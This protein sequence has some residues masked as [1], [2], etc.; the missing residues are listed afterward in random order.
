MRAISLNC[1]PPTCRLHHAAELRET[2]RRKAS[3]NPQL[4]FV[5]RLRR[6]RRTSAGELVDKEELESEAEPVSTD[7]VAVEYVR[8]GKREFFVRNGKHR[9][10]PGA[11]YAEGDELAVKETTIDRTLRGKVVDRLKRLA[12]PEGYPH[13]VGPGFVEY[14]RWRLSAFFFGGAVG[15]FSTQG[16]LLAVGVGRQSA[17]PLAAALQWVIRDGMGRAGRMLFS[18]VGNGFDAETKQ[19]RLMAGFVLNLSCALESVTPAVPHLFLPLACIANM[20]KGAS[21]V[22]AASTRSA[23]YLSFMRRENLG[24]ITAKQETVGVAGDLMGTAMGILLSRYTANS[25]RLAMGA[26][27]TVS[28]AHLFSV[29]KEIKGIQLGTLNRQRAHMLIKYYLEEGKVPDLAEGNR[30]ERILNRPWLD[31]LHAPNIDLG[32]RLQDC[33]P[34]AEAVQYLLKMYKNERYLFTYEDTR[35]KIVLRQDAASHDCLK[36]FLQADY[37]WNRYKDEGVRESR[38]RALL[39]ESYKFANSRFDAFARDAENKGWLTNS[40]LLRP[41]GRRASWSSS[42]AHSRR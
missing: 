23:I 2:E 22:A 15:V 1:P 40:V 31:S 41:I 27:V 30:N 16:L 11:R 7:A 18:Q 17:A 42:L 19:Y 20:A 28:L 35:L 5:A 4:A 21:T 39:E 32:A 6:R 38:N 33:A 26:F 3:R 13:S 9:R 25:R 37:F 29:Y 24:D 34:D 8:N 36:A 10:S 14:T 12:F